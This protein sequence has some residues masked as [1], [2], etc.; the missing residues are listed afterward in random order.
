MRSLAHKIAVCHGDGV[1]ERCGEEIPP[2]TLWR[3][4]KVQAVCAH[5]G[6]AVRPVKVVCRAGRASIESAAKCDVYG[7]CLP[8]YSPRG[9]RLAA[10][11]ERPEAEAY[12]LCAGCGDFLARNDTLSAGVIAAPTEEN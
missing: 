7:R 1:C 4:C 2:G 10:W 11:R 6:D 9:D 5:L 8:I 12:A 3:R